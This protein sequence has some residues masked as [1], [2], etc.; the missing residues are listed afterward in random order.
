MIYLIIKIILN[1][2]SDKRILE[3]RK[4]IEEEKKKHLIRMKQIEIKGENKKKSQKLE[5]ELKN[6]N[7]LQKNKII[8]NKL[9][10]EI[11]S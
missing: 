11:N 10:E 6:K 7:L 5:Y 8:Q 4:A 2:M 9:N 1:K 3:L